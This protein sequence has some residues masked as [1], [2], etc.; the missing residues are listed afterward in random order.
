MGRRQVEIPH[1]DVARVEVARVAVPLGP[2][3]VI[4]ITRVWLGFIDVRTRAAANVRTGIIVVTIA[5]M[6]ARIIVAVAR[7]V[8]P[9]RIV[10]HR[11]LR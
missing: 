5:L 2:S 9:S 6:V 11:H 8:C 1:E 4:A 10:E 3:F 7:V